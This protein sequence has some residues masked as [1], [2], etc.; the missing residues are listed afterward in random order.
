MTETAP[1]LARDAETAPPYAR[2]EALGAAYAA[3][4]LGTNNCRLLIAAPN[5]TGFRVLD[6]FSRVVRLGEGLSSSGQ[7]S[8][9]S[10]ERAL[11][12]LGA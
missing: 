8:A 4:D 1:H 5:A 10:M 3:L 6:S 7:L 12:A 2:A 11:A 9:A